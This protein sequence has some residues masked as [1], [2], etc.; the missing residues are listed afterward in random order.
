M[1]GSQGG[2]RNHGRAA[3]AGIRLAAGG[4]TGSLDTAIAGQSHTVVVV[5]VVVVIEAMAT[6]ERLRAIVKLERG[7]RTTLN[8]RF[9]EI[10]R[11]RISRRCR[12]ASA[13]IASDAFG[14]ATAAAQADGRI[15]RSAPVGY[16]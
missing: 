12:F 14:F 9:A 10:G 6:T 15:V 16:R 2:G 13:L 1:S 11:R 3:G 7:V 5:A 4:R 8:G